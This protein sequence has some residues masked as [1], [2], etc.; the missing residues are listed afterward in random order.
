LDGERNRALY[1]MKSR[2]MAHSKEVREFVISSKGLSIIDVYR[3]SKG[4][5]LIGA[6]RIA[7]QKENLLHAKQNGNGQLKPQVKKVRK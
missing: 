2:G 1:I 3:G 4:K 6:A 5:V 7:K